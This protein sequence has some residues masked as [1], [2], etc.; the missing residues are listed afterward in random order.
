MNKS[1]IFIISTIYDFQDL[2]SDLKYWFQEYGYEAQLSEYNDFQ[3]DLS[4]NSYDA[5]L[6]AIEN[7][8]YYILLI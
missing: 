1:K 4:I 5:C 8:N 2:R 7:C 6:N 3:K